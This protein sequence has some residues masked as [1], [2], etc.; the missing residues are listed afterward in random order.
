M[1]DRQV[2][3]MQV[4][5]QIGQDQL[6]LDQVPDDAGHLV[7]VQLDHRICDLDLFHDAFFL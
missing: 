3:V 1:L 4:D 5:V 6:L 7:A 2:I